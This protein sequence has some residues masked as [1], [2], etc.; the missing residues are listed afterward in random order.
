VTVHPQAWYLLPLLFTVQGCVRTLPQASPA[1]LCQKPAPDMVSWQPLPIGVVFSV[2]APPT[3]RLDTSA[4]AMIVFY[5][6]GRRWVDEELT[7][8]WNLSNRGYSGSMH[9]SL[10]RRMARPEAWRVPAG[11]EPPALPGWLVRSSVAHDSGDYSASVWLMRESPPHDLIYRLHLW[12]ETDSAFVR[13]LAMVRSLR[14]M[15]TGDP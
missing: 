8:F 1:T 10:V 6:G 11:C 3:L 2:S 9:D 13:A 5:H 15:A 12:A 4:A 7:V 14:L